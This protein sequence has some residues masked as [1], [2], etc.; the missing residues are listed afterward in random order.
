MVKDQSLMDD[1][2][3]QRFWERYEM[4][5]VPWDDTQPPP[6]VVQLAADL[7][8]GRALDLGCGYGRT[9]IHLAHNGWHV[10][11]IDFIPQ[12]V[13][14]AE[15]RAETADVVEQTQFYVASVTDLGFLYSRF[16]LAVD[17]GCL[18]AL[19]GKQQVAY[20]DELARLLQ[21]GSVYLLFARLQESQEDGEPRGIAESA[22]C[23]LFADG[24]S[25]EK[26]EIGATCTADKSWKSGWFYFKRSGQ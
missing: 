13:M 18:H 25:L 7:P 24:F 26:S 1:I 21:P 9:A 3:F 2:A 4:G 6:E 8:P 14:E 10:A 5:Q 20:R 17:V 19:Q 11:G 16:T 15:R 23:T 12:A 22:I